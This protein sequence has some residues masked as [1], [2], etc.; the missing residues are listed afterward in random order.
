MKSFIIKDIDYGL[1]FYYSYSLPLYTFKRLEE[2]LVFQKKHG[3]CKG[4]TCSSSRD[5]TICYIPD[6]SCQLYAEKLLGLDTRPLIRK[7]HRMLEIR[8]GYSYSILHRFVFIHD[9]YDKIEIFLSVFLS[10]NTDYYVNTIRWVRNL[11]E[12][13]FLERM[14]PLNISSYQFQQLLGI[15]NNV[16]SIFRSYNDPLDIALKLLRFPNVG[17]KTVFAFLLHSFGLTQYAPVDRYYRRFLLSIGVKGR[18]P[19]KKYCLSSR[20]NCSK[21]TYSN[22]CVYSLAMNKFSEFNGI[23]QS[24]TYIYGR[25][26]NARLRSPLERILI[27]ENTYRILVELKRLLKMIAETNIV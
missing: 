18:D 23:I 3:V 19:N 24:L 13:R 16:S 8:T 11:M 14:K 10:R 25:L 6:N 22:R 17:V 7:L 2:I 9:P 5:Q 26:K 15:I 4:L 12:T 1:S 21:C 27:D 20:L